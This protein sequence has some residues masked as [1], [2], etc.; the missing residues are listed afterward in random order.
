MGSVARLRSHFL[1]TAIVVLHARSADRAATLAELASRSAGLVVGDLRSAT[2]T[3]S[4][5]DQVN[6]IGRMDAVIH[7]AGVYAQK[8]RASTPEGHAG[9]LPAWLPTSAVV[10]P[11]VRFIWSDEI[12]ASRP[13]RRISLKSGQRSGTA[14]SRTPWRPPR[15]YQANI[16]RAPT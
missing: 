3:R 10:R 16:D 1:M 5:A 9:M 8:S 6:A 13:T 14:F 7:N 11:I 15:M 12:A 2:E 4:I